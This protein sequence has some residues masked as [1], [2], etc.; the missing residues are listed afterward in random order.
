VHSVTLA[1]GE[2]D[3]GISCYLLS[4]VTIYSLTWSCTHN[5]GGGELGGLAREHAGQCQESQD[6]GEEHVTNISLQQ[7]GL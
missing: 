1:L 3:R 4:I 2:E 7:I 5:R 6:S